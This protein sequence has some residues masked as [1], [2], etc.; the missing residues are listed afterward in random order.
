VHPFTAKDDFLKF[1]TISPIDEYRF[2]FYELKIDGIFSENPKTAVLASEYFS[3]MHE[4]ET[5]IYSK[6]I[7]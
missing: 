4:A 7:S 1:S 2:Y 5:V 3:Y 6:Y